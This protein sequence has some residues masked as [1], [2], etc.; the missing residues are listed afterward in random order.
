MS[1]RLV[2]LGVATVL[3]VAGIGSATEP[4]DAASCSTTYGQH[5]SGNLVTIA[6]AIDGASARMEYENPSLCSGFNPALHGQSF[7]AW[8]VAV[9]NH[10]SA[11][12]AGTGRC[13]FQVGV[14]KCQSTGCPQTGA[15]FYFVAHGWPGG[16]CGVARDPSAIPKGTATSGLHLFSVFNDTTT[17]KLVAK[18]DGATVFNP[19]SFASYSVC[20]G[21]VNDAAWTDEVMNFGDQSGGPN[22]DRQNFESV[23]LHKSGAWLDVVGAAIPCNGGPTWP[24]QRCG[25]SVGNPKFW[26]WDSRF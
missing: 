7:S 18:I 9:Q 13:I 23:K 11:G 8:W 21:G 4:V 3:A 26:A 12:C 1:R 25:W 14:A 24:H 5:F 22:A 2:A 16:Y 17:G 15:P 19:Y 20:W 6:G 10:Q